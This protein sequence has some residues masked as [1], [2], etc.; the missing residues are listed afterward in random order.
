MKLVSNGR[1]L[2]VYDIS[3]PIYHLAAGVEVPHRTPISRAAGG[4]EGRGACRSR[5]LPDAGNKRS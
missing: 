4:G 5:S 2:R 3:G 1:N